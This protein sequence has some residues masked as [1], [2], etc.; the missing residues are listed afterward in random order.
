LRYGR[1]IKLDG[2]DAATFGKGI[3]KVN[4]MFWGEYSKIND[5]LQALQASINKYCPTFPNEYE[6]AAHICLNNFL[7]IIQQNP[8]LIPLYTELRLEN[9][10]NKT[11]SVIDVVYPQKIVDYKTSTQYTVK[12]KQPNIIQAAMC[13]MNLKECM[14]LNV[15]H[16]EFQ[17]LRFKKYQFVDIDS[18]IIEEV[19]NIINNTWDNIHD[20]V[21]PKNE[22]ACWFCDYKLI[23]QREKEALRKN[24]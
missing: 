13:S 6:D 10:N 23:C 21:F 17:Y 4:E 24:V 15:N 1:R 14:G 12:A 16:V 9:P 18:K 22:K 5:P 7:G 19:S 2:G 20:D 11:V 8:K 3:H